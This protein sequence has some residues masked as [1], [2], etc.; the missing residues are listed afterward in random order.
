MKRF[1]HHKNT[2][3]TRRNAIPPMTPPTMV[4]SFLKSYFLL[5]PRVLLAPWLLQKLRLILFE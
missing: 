2:V 5:K 1:F 4:D 3:I